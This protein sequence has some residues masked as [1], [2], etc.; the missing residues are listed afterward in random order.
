MLALPRGIPA[1][2]MAQDALDDI[3]LV[4]AD[5]GD[6]LYALAAELADSGVVFPDFG[7]KPGPATL[8]AFVELGV[9]VVE[10]FWRK[11]R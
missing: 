4:G 5:G 11:R 8:A 6:D 1:M 2:Q 9:G 3:G 10:C 7:D